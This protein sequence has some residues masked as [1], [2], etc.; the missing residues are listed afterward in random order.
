M[1]ISNIKV[2]WYNP[3]NKINDTGI[4][5]YYQINGKHIHFMVLY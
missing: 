2:I 1:D 3:S 5:P 4:K